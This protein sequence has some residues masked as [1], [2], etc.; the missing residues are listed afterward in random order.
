MVNR[1]KINKQI[2]KKKG[3]L[4][5]RGVNYRSGEKNN[6]IYLYKYIYKYIHYIYE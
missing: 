6:E 3:H 2:N 4:I 1:N 5:K